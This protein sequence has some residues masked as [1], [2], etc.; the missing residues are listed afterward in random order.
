MLLVA[1]TMLGTQ[2]P[3]QAQDKK[4]GELRDTCGAPPKGN[5]WAMQIER[6]V[7]AVDEESKGK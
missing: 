2:D 4:V 3:V 1:L 7:A 6:L 5:P